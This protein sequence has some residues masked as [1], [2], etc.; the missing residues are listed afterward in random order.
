MDLNRIN[1]AS[2]IIGNNPFI[3]KSK[4]VKPTVDMIAKL[5]ETMS[6]YSFKALTSQ[7]A[8]LAQMDAQNAVGRKL[9]IAA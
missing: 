6:S 7:I 5:K 4:P 3:I 9:D 8:A 1:S 2:K